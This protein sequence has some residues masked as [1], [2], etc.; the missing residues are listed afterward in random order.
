MSGLTN[1]VLA[2]QVQ[3]LLDTQKLQADY[4]TAWLGGSADGGPNLDGRYPFVDLSGR[5]IL[6]P[7]PATFN[8]MVSGP[9]ALAD[10]AKVAAELARDLAQGHADRADAQ[11]ALSEA[12]RGAAIDARNLAQEHRSHAGTHEANARYWAELAQ[13]S[14]QGSADDRAVVEQL[15]AET[16]DNAASASQ[17]ASDAAAS[18]ALAATFDPALYALKTD[19]LNSAR[20]FGMIDPARI[21]VLLSQYPVM[22][23]GGL[24]DL[25][26]AQQQ[27]IGPGTIVATTDGKRWAYKGDGGSKTAASGY[28]EQGDVTPIWDAIADK[29]LNF[30]STIALVPGL[31]AALDGKAAAG[32]GH[33][34]GEVSGLQ[35]ALD[36]KAASGSFPTFSQ[37]RTSYGSVGGTVYF[38]PSDK[39]LHYNGSNFEL[40]GG[41]L[42][43]S[44][45]SLS[46]AMV[47]HNASASDWTY[48]AEF[49]RSDSSVAGPID[50]RF[51]QHNKWYVRLRGEPGGFALI[52]GGTDNPVTLRAGHA[53]FTGNVILPS[54][55]D[56]F[57][58]LGSSTNYNYS[59]I[60]AGDHFQIREAGDP[61]KVRLQIAYP[62][63]DVTIQSTVVNAGG[64]RLWSAADPTFARTTLFNNSGVGH[65][66]T[67]DGYGAKFFFSNGPNSTQ[68]YGLTLG[69]G[70]EYAASSYSMDL[71]VPRKGYTS[72][73]YLH[74]RSTEG[75]G[76]DAWNKIKAGYA[77]NAGTLGG[78][79]LAEGVI[80]DTVVSR[81]GGGDIMARDFTTSRSNG[82]GCVYFGTSGTRYLY[83]DG[84]AY[85]LGGFG[86]IYTDAHFTVS[87]ASSQNTVVKR[88]GSGDLSI[89]NVVFDN[90]KS[91]AVG[92]YDPT[93]TQAVWAMGAA[94]KLGTGG[95]GDYANHYGLA[96]SYEPGY[97]GAGNNVQSKPGLSHQLLLQHYGTT[98]TAIG[99]GIWTVG[100]I[101]AGD[102]IVSQTGKGF[103]NAGYQTGR[104]RIWSFNN[105]DGY[106]LSYFEGSGGWGGT[107]TIGLHFGSAST[108]AGS[109]HK[110]RAGGDAYHS[111]HLYTGGGIQASGPSNFNGQVTLN[112]AIQ[113]NGYLTVAGGLQ[114][115][116]G[117][118]YS[119]NWWRSTGQ[120][121][122]FNADYSVGIWAIKGGEV[123]T[124]NG[125][126]F[127]SEGALL[128]AGH[129]YQNGGS[130]RVPVTTYS[131]S[132]PSG[133][134]DGDVHIV[135]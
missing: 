40:V 131:Q 58:S 71:A 87:A 99:T 63:G 130:N 80:G 107:D 94:Y 10:V 66:S 111:N 15:A 23:A 14:G 74:Y 78:R 106:G 112:G 51:H 76:V 31:Q 79:A 21:P 118:A 56:R 13:G 92:V 68:A 43:A 84:S 73:G 119:N 124:Y 98:M 115:T 50:L 57:I 27:G 97:G 55:A 122:W 11:R 81:N 95:S 36:A 25:T 35:A 16:A 134:T 125:A 2:Q 33:S 128:S 60:S 100:S 59:L 37:I 114:I 61:A 85:V 96:W 108:E 69:L 17:D 32:H 45:V 89:R 101:Q 90:V 75:G 29:P 9:A 34:I 26:T 42:S 65:G 116:G 49:S 18:A 129:V 30:P 39:Y 104:N 8:D 3:A 12:A 86:S 127:Y 72:E 53:S 113:T 54:G 120:S 83:F 126:N 82:T 70:A 6:V 133:G 93:S 110:F 121:G 103:Q 91:G 20:L 7:S 67:P 22:S 1:S 28:I 123:R 64:H 4:L 47:I 5:E 38:G 109:A 132:A 19:G 62:N 77:D 41:S 24:A 88:D 117:L 44:A 135:W 48:N 102:V 105:A 46:G 52:E